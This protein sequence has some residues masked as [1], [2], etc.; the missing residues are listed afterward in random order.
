M[1]GEYELLMDLIT[2]RMSVRKFKP[3]PIPEEYLGKVLEAARWA[4]SGANSQPW[5]FVVVRDPEV[6]KELYGAYIDINTRYMFWMEQQRP[7]ELRH[8]SYQVPGDAQEQ[9]R[10]VLGREGWANAPAL[11]VVLGDGRKQWGTVMGA[12][13]F[14]RGMT[15]LTDGLSNASQ[16]IQLAAASLG[17]GSQWVTIHIQEP[18]KKILGVPDLHYIHVI[19]PLGYPAV[20]RRPGYRREISTM[21]HYDRYNMDK[22]LPDDKFIDFIKELRQGTK[23]KYKSSYGEKK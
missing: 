18:F 14:G 6:K 17:L 4:M 15:H 7:I 16:N 5:E 23:P 3:D 9:L 1:M 11:I 22:Y 21:V 20:E 19:I 13:T 12:H 2:K 8:P 10:T